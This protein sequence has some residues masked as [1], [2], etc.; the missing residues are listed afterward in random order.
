MPHAVGTYKRGP[1]EN[2]FEIKAT[3]PLVVAL[4]RTAKNRGLTDISLAK[5]S[6]WSQSLVCQ[7]RLGKRLP[8]LRSLRD[9]GEAVGMKLTWSTISD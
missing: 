1:Y 2:S 8:G 5:R 9:L 7:V 4:F 6:G 3:D